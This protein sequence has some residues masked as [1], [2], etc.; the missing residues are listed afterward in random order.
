[1][2]L[3]LTSRTTYYWDDLGFTATPSSHPLFIT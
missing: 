1:M 2:S 3:T